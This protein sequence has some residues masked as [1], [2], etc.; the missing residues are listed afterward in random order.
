MDKVEEGVLESQKLKLMV[1]FLYIND[2][3]FIWTHDKQELQW[4]LKELNKTHSGLKFTR[5][6]SKEK[7]SI[8][9]LSVS[10]SNGN[11]YTNLHSKATDCH[12]YLKNTTSHQEHEEIH[13]L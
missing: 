8:L 10:L 3:F 9:D 1:W 6:S 7:I 12:Q 4:F 2:I 5:E 11:H 13:H